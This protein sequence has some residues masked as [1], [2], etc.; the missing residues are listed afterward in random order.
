M[1]YLV[2]IPL[3]GNSQIQTWQSYMYI[4]NNIYVYIFMFKINKDADIYRTL[5]LFKSKTQDWKYICIQ[6]P[7][8]RNSKKHG[9]HRMI[10]LINLLAVLDVTK[11]Q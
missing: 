11:V 9:L 1:Y 8:L 5:T 3:T 7:K 2:F 10:V 6:N 4:Q